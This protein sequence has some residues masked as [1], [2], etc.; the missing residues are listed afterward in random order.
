VL[1]LPQLHARDADRAG[2][3][4]GGQRKGRTSPEPSPRAGSECA[5]ALEDNGAGASAGTAAAKPSMLKTSSSPMPTGCSAGAGDERYG[6][7]LVAAA[8]GAGGAG[9][10]PT[11]GDAHA[12]GAHGATD[13]R[14]YGGLGVSREACGD[15]GGCV[16]SCK[17]CSCWSVAMVG[18]I[19]NGLPAMLKPRQT[20]PSPAR[21]STQPTT[22]LAPS[23][24]AMFI[25]ARGMEV[26]AYPRSR[27]LRSVRLLFLAGMRTLWSGAWAAPI[28]EVVKRALFP[29]AGDRGAPPHLAGACLFRRGGGLSQRSPSAQTQ[30]P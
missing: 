11:F 12:N 8:A 26:V 23:S 14:E 2:S 21:L 22:G 15:D 13:G 3:G 25:L 10:S 27:L 1:L 18:A 6:W 5:S 24:L 29:W 4:D 28:M 30:R 20:R 19:G 17:C 9:L 7:M 16:G